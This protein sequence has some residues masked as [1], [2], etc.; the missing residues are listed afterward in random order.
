MDYCITDCMFS[1]EAQSIPPEIET[2]NWKRKNDS[3]NQWALALT[4][5]AIH[6]FHSL[7]LIVLL[8]VSKNDALLILLLV[9]QRHM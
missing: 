6:I 8:K 7:K 9:L 1:F 2:E 5:E 3:F 4:I